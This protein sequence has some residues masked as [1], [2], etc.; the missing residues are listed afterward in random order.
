MPA[1]LGRGQ[2]APALCGPGETGDRVDRSL[3]VRVQVELLRRAVGAGLPGV[4]RQHRQRLQADQRFERAARLLQ[5]LVEH[6]AHRENGGAGVD[7][8]A[9]D[10]HLAHFAAGLGRGLEQRDLDTALRQQQRADQPADAGADD[11]HTRV[12]QGRRLSHA[13]GP[14]NGP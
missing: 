12:A 6:P 4:A 5:D 3:Q 13:G 2:V 9:I 11:D 7:A 10:Q 1:R 14:A 8:L